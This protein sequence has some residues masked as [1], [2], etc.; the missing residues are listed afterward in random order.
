L[1]E[2]QLLYPIGGQELTDGCKQKIQD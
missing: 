2:M 1:I